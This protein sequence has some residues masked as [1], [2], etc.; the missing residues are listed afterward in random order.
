MGCPHVPFEDFWALVSISQPRARKFVEKRKGVEGDRKA[1][2]PRDRRMGSASTSLYEGWW[3][4][5]DQKLRPSLSTHPPSMA[6]ALPFSLRL[7]LAR[8]LAGFCLCEPSGGRGSHR[9]C[10]LP[11]HSQDAPGPCKHR[12]KEPGPLWVEVP[13]GDGRG[14]QCPSGMPGRKKNGPAKAWISQMVPWRRLRLCHLLDASV[15]DLHSAGLG[16]GEGDILE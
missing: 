16:A 3:Q 13:P 8:S 12:L 10:N 9:P 1:L 15:R 4:A 6:P 5:R 2:E 14:Q 7:P 11:T